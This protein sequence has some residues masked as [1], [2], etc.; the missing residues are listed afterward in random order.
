MPPRQRKK[1]IS[2]GDMFQTL[3]QELRR[4]AIEPN[5]TRYTPHEKQVRFHSSSAKVRLYIGGNRSGKTVGG[6][7]ED[8]YYLR[9]NHPHKR[10]PDVPIRG[11]IVCVD[12][13]Q[14]INQI[15]IP[16]LKQWLPP[17][18]LING[19]WE[20]SYNSE[21]KELRLANGSTCEL[22]TYEQKLE[23][24]AGTSR[25]FIHYDEEPPYQIYRE[26]QMRLLD[27]D[28]DAWMTMTP[29]N[30][31]TWVYDSIYL[32]GS[33]GAR[34]DIDVIEVNVH[35]NP[36]VKAEAI[37]RILG[38]I[39]D[40]DE[41]AARE[42]GKF[43]QLGGLVYKDF[44]RSKHVIDAIN[45]R[46]KFYENWEM[47]RSMDHGFNNPTAWLWHLI[48]PDAQTII[49]FAEHYQREMIVSEHA[50]V[51]HE[52]D[53]GF[54]RVPDLCVGDPA[55][56][57]RNG[58]NG[59]SILETYAQHDIF[60]APG[61]NDVLTGVERVANYLKTNPGTQ[62]PY[63]LI[64]QSCPN[65]IRELERLRWK[66][67]ASKTAQFQNNA[68][69][70]IHKHNDHAADAARYFFTM[71]PDLTPDPKPVTRELPQDTVTERY[72][73]ALA[74]LA[75]AGPSTEWKKQQTSWE[76]E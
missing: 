64:T 71:M 41:R 60:I 42:T 5:I 10:I 74:R 48:S 70:E 40:E 73:L 61:N 63:W 13:N 50:R 57:Q 4:Q 9:R 76:W 3:G 68:K 16:K 59:T 47:A 34:S 37:E 66:T 35:E 53:K 44:A 33:D 8:I 15:I 21:R 26:C 11:R 25:H 29:V 28:G 36:Y 65:L 49:T 46:N 22:M 31:M 19:S 18:L 24:F 52:M 7:T 14:G 69:E 17:S 54:G 39:S 43:V 72:D 1:D 62:R 67:Y 20:D 2:I 27:T 55:I 51:V 75:A 58:I 38:D 23:S 30:G 32:P 6:I 56:E 45:P 12:F